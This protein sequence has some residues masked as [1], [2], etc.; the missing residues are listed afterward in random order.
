MFNKKLIY[1]L[2]FGLIGFAV[3]SANPPN[4]VLI[5]ADDLGW[6][7]V[8]FN[9][10]NFYETPNIDRLASQGVFFSNAYSN[11][12]ICAPSRAALLSGQYG[13]RTGFYTNHSPLRGESSWRKVIPTDNQHKLDYSK[14]TLA[15]VLQSNGYKTIHIGKWH[16]GDTPDNYPEKHGFDINIAGH[17]RGKPNTYFSP[18]DLPNLENGPDGEYLTDR[19]T[20]EAIQFIEKNKDD[21]FFVNMAYYSPHTPIQAKD[22]LIRKYIPR[23]HSNGQ[24]DPIYAAM[25]ETLDYNVGRLADCIKEQGLDNNTI[26]VFFSDN[27]T[28][29][30]L[31]ANKPLR[32]YK[33]TLYEGGIRVPLIIKS[34]KQQSGLTNSTPVM[35]ADIY[36]TLLDLAGLDKPKN[37]PLDGKS[38]KPILEGNSTI[39]REAIFWHFPA[40]LQGEYGMST[41]WRTTPVSVVRKG[42]YKLLEFLDDGHLEL[43]DL[44]NDL[45]EKYNLADKYPEI[46]N[47]LKETLIQWRKDL[48][49]PYP[50]ESNPDYDAAS[51]PCSIKIGDRSEIYMTKEESKRYKKK[52]K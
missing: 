5:V 26:V 48:D 11:A 21:P 20:T 27:G 22:S 13:A 44:K 51:I 46:A 31:A 40:Y 8:S 30:P 17:E 18:Y 43:Y 6:S 29:P 34:P 35:G 47:D 25:I 39:E 49:V 10:S 41:I 42:N 1:T 7:D 36:P 2:I 14:K 33:G 45:G 50:L 32:A 15:N 19:L 16:L 28:T 23:E 12:Q 24:H 4:I 38:L 9:G 3:Q 52:N 37:Y